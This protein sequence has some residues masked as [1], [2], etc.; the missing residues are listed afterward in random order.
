MDGQDYLNQISESA[1]PKKAS[2][3]GI[4]SPRNLKIGGIVAG[5]IIIIIVIASIFSGMNKKPSLKTNIIS[6]R[7]YMDST[8]SA[9]GSYQKKVKSSKL[10]SYSASLSS[11]LSNTSGNITTY[12]KSKYDFKDS[13]ITKKMKSNEATH[14]NELESELFNAKINGILDR[15]YAHKMAYEISI[16]TAKEHAIIEKVKD[17]DFKE[18]LTTSYNSLANLYTQFNDF[19]EGQ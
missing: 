7:M 15:I 12:L 4:L 8:N 14:L 3:S 11:V 18:T 17:T 5:V 1:K 9:I 6:M 2:R 10:R 13:Q 19:S 16:I